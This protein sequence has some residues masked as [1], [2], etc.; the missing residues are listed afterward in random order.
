MQRPEA[1]QKKMSFIIVTGRQKTKAGWAD[2]TE[3][4]A[5]LNRLNETEPT[6]QLWYN[7]TDDSTKTEPKTGLKYKLN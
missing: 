2:R 6:G 3:Y 5:Q 7:R 1:G 4:K